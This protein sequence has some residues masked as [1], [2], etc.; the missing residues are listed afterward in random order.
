MSVC[1]MATKDGE[2]REYCAPY[3]ILTFSV[4]TGEIVNNVVTFVPELPLAKWLEMQRLEMANFLKIYVEFNE[5]F[6]DTG[7]EFTCYVD[8]I[9]G[10][11]YY[12]VFTPRGEF[13]PN[14]PPILEAYMQYYY[15]FGDTALRVAHQ[16]L[17][18]TKEQIAEV[19]R[20]IYGE[21]ASDPVDIIMHDFIVNRYFFGDFSSATPGV[22]DYTFEELN[23]PI[24]QLYLA[25]EAYIPA[26][27]S[28]AHDAL[29]HGTQIGERI[30]QEILGP[31]TSKDIILL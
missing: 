6:W 16:N 28:S 24:G 25:G 26:I 3:A 18:I 30:M 8:E 15:L 10:R 4:G 13:L 29:V 27:H 22:S 2:V 5:T 9:N 12:P 17:E 14:K 31:L 7:V 19:M 20:N 1:V 23:H 21:K 11:E